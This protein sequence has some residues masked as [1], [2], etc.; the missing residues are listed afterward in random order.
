MVNF[1]EIHSFCLALPHVTESFP[2]DK[3]TLVYKVGGK[4]FALID[5]ESISSMNLK[6]E[7]ERAVELRERHYFILPGYHMNK[8]HWNTI[9]FIPELSISFLKEQIQHS[10]DLVWN[11]LSKKQKADYGK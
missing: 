4:M 8:K 3:T 11:S 9:E 5:V 7:P 6:C 10:Y 2:F 1:D